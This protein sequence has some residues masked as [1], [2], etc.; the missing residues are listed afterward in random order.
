MAIGRSY[1]IDGHV[2]RR[3]GRAS[4]SIEERSGMKI[5]IEERERKI[6]IRLGHLPSW[7]E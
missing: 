2:E 7:V 4:G 6:A 3:V 1:V 5:R